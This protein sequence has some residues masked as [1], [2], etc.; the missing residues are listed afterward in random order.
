M[1]KRFLVLG[2]GM[3]GY[4]IAQD[5]LKNGHDVTLADI[6]KNKEQKAKQLGA[7]F[8]QLD[9][10]DSNELVRSAKWYDVMVSAVE[11]PEYHYKG[12]EAAIAAHCN[13]TD[14]G[15]DPE[16]LKKE[17]LLHRE[18]KQSGITAIPDTGVCP[19]ITNVLIGLGDSKLD[20]TESIH[21]FVG[22]VPLKPK[23]PFNYS[24]IFSVAVLVNE[25]L[26]QA[27]IIKDGKI[28]RVPGMSGVQKVYFP[29]FR[30]MEAAFVAG[31]TSSLTRTFLGKVDQMYEKTLRYP[32]HFKFMK[33]LMRRFKKRERLERYLEYTLPHNQ[34][35]ALLMKIVVQ[36]EKDGRDAGISYT[37]IDKYTDGMTAMAR[38]TAWSASVVAQLVANNY[39]IEKGVLEQEVYV[40]PIKFLDEMAM[41]EIAI[42]EEMFS[43]G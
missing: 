1:K 19:G 31:A 18:A 11:R 5:L 23:P 12:L 16:T 9:I 39:I 14:L 4:Y 20:K 6:D 15:A 24:L 2:A 40:P 34:E 29:G 30:M 8:K 10:N 43:N 32:G 38:T 13:F 33:R 41:R 42:K 27:E 36:G 37:L 21:Y 22:G 7:S 3:M 26:E 28:C 17:F 25:Y 35:D